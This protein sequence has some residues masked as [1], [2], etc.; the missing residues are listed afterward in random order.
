MSLSASTTLAVARD[1]AHPS[2]KT[3]TLDDQE[4]TWGKALVSAIPTEILAAYTAGL[5]L[6][7][8]LAKPPAAA[9]AYLVFR[10]AWYFGWLLTTPA[11]SW[12]LFRRKAKAST[13][14]VAADVAGWNAAG[15][16]EV[17][18][19]TLAAAAWFTAMPGSPWQVHLSNGAFQLTTL[20]ALS[21]GSLAVGLIAPALTKPTT[22]SPPPVPASAASEAPQ[23]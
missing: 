7:V 14:V 16:A 21:V 20:A 13:T 4:V 3:V 22:Y 11:I 23:V 8:G 1:A 10:F 17:I 5:G 15:R 18:A 2:D 6:V 9:D 19:P 12:L